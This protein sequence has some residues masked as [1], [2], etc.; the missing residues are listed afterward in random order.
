MKIVFCP[1][2]NSILFLPFDFY[3][4]SFLYFKKNG[5]LSIKEKSRKKKESKIQ[6]IST[7]RDGG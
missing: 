5:K 2:K 3:L 4:F 7:M 6:I 1:D